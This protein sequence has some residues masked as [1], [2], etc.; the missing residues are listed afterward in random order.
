MVKFLLSCLIWV[1]FVEADSYESFANSLEA[2]RS[3]SACKI[4]K[5]IL[6]SGERDEQL[7]GAIARVCLKEDYLYTTT[8]IGAKLRDT[9]E[10]RAN[11]TLLTSLALQKKLL[12][13]FMYDDTDISPFYLPVTEHPLSYAFSAIRDKSYTTLSHHPKVVTFEHKGVA[14]RVYI[15]K[16]D[17]G[18]VIIEIEYPD[19]HK[20]KRRYF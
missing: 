18:R 19:G 14:Y 9:K 2:N 4:G 3:A 10:S 6:L 13:Q 16:S 8:I 11:A 7:L 15:D 20:E 5:K 12:Y 1:S 17:A